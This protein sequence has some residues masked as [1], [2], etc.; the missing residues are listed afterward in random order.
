MPI[1]LNR[2]FAEERAG[3]PDSGQ[4]VASSREGRLHLNEATAGDLQRIEGI[5]GERARAIL[6]H[7]RAMGRFETWEDVRAVPGLD[8][9]LLKRIRRAAMVD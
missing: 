9:V 1:D 3:T 7:R 2:A 6:D 4:H 8:G 5:D